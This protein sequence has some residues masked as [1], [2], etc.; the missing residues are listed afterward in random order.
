MLM[1]NRDSYRLQISHGDDI[2]TPEL[3]FAGPQRSSDP[4]CLP[5]VP[6]WHWLG[7]HQ[8]ADSPVALSY[9]LAVSELR[10]CT[11][12]EDCNLSCANSK[13]SGLP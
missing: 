3:R 12:D 9:L 13:S 11:E 5:L 7:P 4:R 6:A 2:H 8:L 1:A 10:A